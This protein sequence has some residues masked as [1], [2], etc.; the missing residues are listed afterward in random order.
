MNKDVIDIDYKAEYKR[1]KEVEAENKKL[2]STIVNMSIY[3]FQAGIDMT[4]VFEE[5][6]KNLQKLARR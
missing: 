1:L 4:K 3:M 5:I 2:R 6:D